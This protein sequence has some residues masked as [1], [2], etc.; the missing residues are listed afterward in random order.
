VP[1]PE[2]RGRRGGLVGGSRFE[3]G[4]Q[5]GIDLTELEKHLRELGARPGVRG[6]VRGFAGQKAP[7]EQNRLGG[8]TQTRERAG[9][10]QLAA[11][12]E[13]IAHRPR[14]R[15]PVPTRDRRGEHPARV[16]VRGVELDGPFEAGDGGFHLVAG[17]EQTGEAHGELEALRRKRQDAQ[18]DLQRVVLAALSP[19]RVGQPGR[20]GGMA[21]GLRQDR[22]IGPLRVPKA[23]LPLVSLGCA[24]C[25]G[26]PGH[27]ARL[28]KASPPPPWR[29]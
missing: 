5:L 10:H 7:I 12:R 3:Q 9:E 27:R 26:G 13:P 6:G 8:A 29:L 1:E 28:T 17:V 16:G 23:A 18:Q 21:G 25:F 19:A 22:A 15:R 2:L 24:E 4:L 11:A 20:G 14:R